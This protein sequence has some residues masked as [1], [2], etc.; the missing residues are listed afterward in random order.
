MPLIEAPTRLPIV[1]QAAAGSVYN[2]MERVCMV[3][4]Q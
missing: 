2:V 4:V 3:T 1:L